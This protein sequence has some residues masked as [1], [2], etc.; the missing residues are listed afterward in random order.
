LF[1]ID[2]ENF[3]LYKVN[4]IISYSGKA[5]S[6][7]LVNKSSS[8]IPAAL[9]ESN[10]LLLILNGIH[11]QHV[12]FSVYQYKFASREAFILSTS[13]FGYFAHFFLVISSEILAGVIS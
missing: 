10:F 7:A 8:E 6:I 9:A 3:V 4:E 5:N 13:S 2:H 12:W 11:F 1:V